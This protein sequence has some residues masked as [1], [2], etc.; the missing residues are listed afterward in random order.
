MVRPP[1]VLIIVWNLLTGKCINRLRFK[2]PKPITC[3]KIKET[4]VISSCVGGLVRM[5]NME[6]ASLI[7]VICFYFKKS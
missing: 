6:S 7:K 3:V 4:V 1:V 5:W 2:H